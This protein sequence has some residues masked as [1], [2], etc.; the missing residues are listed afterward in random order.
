MPD[1]QKHPKITCAPFYALKK[2]NKDSLSTCYVVK[3]RL[4]ST[5]FTA[6]EFSKHQ[7]HQNSWQVAQIKDYSQG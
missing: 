7:K 6:I 3:A 5:R 1:L 2:Q 4:I